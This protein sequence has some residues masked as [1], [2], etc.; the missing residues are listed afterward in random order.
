MAVHSIQCA[1]RIAAYR[2]NFRVSRKHGLAGEAPRASRFLP[3]AARRRQLRGR[4]AGGRKQPFRQEAR[5]RCLRAASSDW[6][7]CSMR[8][9]PLQGRPR[10]VK[11]RGEHL[12]IFALGGDLFLGSLPKPPQAQVA[13]LNHRGRSP[14]GGPSLPMNDRAELIFACLRLYP[15]APAPCLS[16]RAATITPNCPSLMRSAQAVPRRV[17]SM[18]SAAHGVPPRCT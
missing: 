4:R 12:E 2:S 6:R 7:R 1:R 14:T 3:A 9:G 16:P 8:Q 5:R 17:A 15:A 13:R 18:R 10:F 11:S